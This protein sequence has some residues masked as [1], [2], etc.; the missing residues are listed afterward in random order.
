[1]PSVN[2]I[3]LKSAAKDFVSKP[4]NLLKAGSMSWLSETAKHGN[5]IFCLAFP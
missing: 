3:F 1:M 5:L 4:V 2:A